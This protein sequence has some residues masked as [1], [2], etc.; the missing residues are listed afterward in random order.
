MPAIQSIRLRRGTAAQW[1]SVN[2]VLA[3][4]EMGI[5]TDTR[6]FKFGTGAAAWSSIPYASAGGSSG[7]GFF[8]SD[9]APVGPNIGDI[10][11]CSADTGD[12]AGKSFVRYDGYWVELNPGTL[13]PTGATGPAGPAG[14]T[15]PAGPTG[16]TGPAGPTGATGPAG[17]TGPTGPAGP[18]GVVA[19]TAP[20]TYNSGT[21]TVGIDGNALGLRL[22]TSQSFSSST[23]VQVNDV[24]SSTYEHYK[25]LV[26]FRASG[27]STL[28]LRMRTGGADFTSNK[29]FTIGYSFTGTI[30]EGDAT[31]GIAGWMDVTGTSAMEMNFFRPFTST[32]DTAYT[33]AQT[34]PRSGNFV[35]GPF[36]AGGGVRENRSDTGF[37][38]YPDSGN[39]TGTVRVYGVLN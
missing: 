6:K 16:A 2:P 36:T 38:I 7:G 3:A 17:P 35:Y 20:I 19:A 26:S 30:N 14:A 11:Y 29:Y 21:Q 23:A 12:L 8:V 1:Q 15:G 13:G 24:F 10:W 39:I 9:V 5:E 25:V 27:N 22:I 32:S 4:G 28:R 18:S 34:G 37:T 33:I 31:S